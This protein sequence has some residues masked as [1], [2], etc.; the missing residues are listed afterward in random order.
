MK[1][2]RHLLL[3][4]LLLLN[5]SFAYSQAGKRVCL[6]Q[7]QQKQLEKKYNLDPTPPTGNQLAPFGFD[8][9]FGELTT[10]ESFRGM[11]GYY[12]DS[13]GVHP[14]IYA[15]GRGL[16]VVGSGGVEKTFAIADYQRAF[17]AYVKLLKETQYMR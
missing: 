2:Y 7:Q 9:K 10:T 13:V 11:S 5:A 12:C 17:A 16:T 3:S 8:A 4:V 15:S 14:T 1:Y 6:E